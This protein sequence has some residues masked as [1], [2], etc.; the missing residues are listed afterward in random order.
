[1]D[2]VRPGQTFEMRVNELLGMW[3]PHFGVNWTVMLEIGTPY[4]T[5]L[6][7]GYVRETKTA[8]LKENI[9]EDVSPI[10]MAQEIY[11]Q[12]PLEFFH[13]RNKQPMRGEHLQEY[14]SG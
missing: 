5:L 2:K 13:N 1:M 8:R 4:V 14:I 9:Y 10:V 3:F 11:L 12:L 6:S 7:R